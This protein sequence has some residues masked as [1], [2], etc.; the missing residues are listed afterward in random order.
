[1]CSRRKSCTCSYFCVQSS[2][3]AERDELRDKAK[4][5]SVEKSALK[6]NEARLESE[7]ADST[8]AVQLCIPVFVLDI[9]SKVLIYL[10]TLL[11]TYRVMSKAFPLLAL[12][13][14]PVFLR[15][16]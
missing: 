9:L 15:G 1:M 3:Q 13:P 6:C 8:S 11:Q 16:Y 12:T 4:R 14:I 10:P 2:R 7:T 5:T